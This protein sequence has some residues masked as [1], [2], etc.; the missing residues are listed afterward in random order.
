ML[1]FSRAAY[2]LA[3]QSGQW[4]WCE[5]R[6]VVQRALSVVD[7][8]KSNE[9][10]IEDR[11]CSVPMMMIWTADSSL[12]SSTASPSGLILDTAAV[13]KLVPKLPEYFDQLCLASAWS[14]GPR[15]VQPRTS[16]FEVW[17]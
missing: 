14:K 4:F 1:P 2:L 3:T 10:V 8:M 5:S 12:P 7:R 13:S 9:R 15:K 16:L 11:P 6:P 17:R